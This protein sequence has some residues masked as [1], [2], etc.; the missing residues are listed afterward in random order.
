MSTDTDDTKHTLLKALRSA[1]EDAEIA[2]DYAKDGDVQT[3]RGT[4]SALIR[5]A[6][7]AIAKAEGG[8]S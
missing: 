1:I 8:A 5:A 4:L 3:A 2:K 6:R 7:A